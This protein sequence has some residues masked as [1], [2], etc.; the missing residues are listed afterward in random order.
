MLY[1]LVAV[2]G[3]LII[4]YAWNATQHIEFPYNIHDIMYPLLQVSYTQT[5][6]GVHFAV[7]I[8]PSSNSYHVIFL[9]VYL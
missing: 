5:H 9:I 3:I 6:F 1:S 2:V 7:Y 8:I 4:Q